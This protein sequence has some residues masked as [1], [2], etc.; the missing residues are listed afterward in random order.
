VT[1]YFNTVS[2]KLYNV[3]KW[4]GGVFLMIHIQRFVCWRLGPKL[5]ETLGGG[6]QLRGVGHWRHDF[7]GHMCV[8]N[9]FFVSF[10]FL[11]A[12][13]WVAFPTC[14]HCHDVSSSPQAP[15]NGTSWQW[16]EIS[17]TIGPN[18]SLSWFPQVLSQRWKS[19]IAQKIDT[20]EVELLSWLNHVSQ[21]PLELVFRRILE[22]FEDTGYIQAS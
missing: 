1:A 20:R 14:S 5:L 16:P 11:S 9:P 3:F 12:M 19:Q 22:R 8:L 6:A 13:K 21:K 15:N 10:C 7:E 2:N 4:V 18:K 17:E